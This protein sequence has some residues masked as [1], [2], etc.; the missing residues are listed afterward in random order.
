MKNLYESFIVTISMF[1]KL[2][3]PKVEWSAQNM[4][5][6]FT[7]L[8]IIG[9][10]VGISELLWQIIATKFALN[11]VFYSVVAVILPIIIT[12]GIHLDGYIDSCDAIFSYGDKDKKLAILSD[13]TVGAFGVLYLLIYLLL[14][15]GLWAQLFQQNVS[16]ISFVAPYIIGRVVGGFLIKLEQPAKKDGLM[17]IFKNSEKP[18][19][20]VFFLI[21][22]SIFV[23]LLLAYLSLYLLF[24]VSI[25]LLIFI[26]LCRRYVYKAFGG[27]TGDLVGFS[28]SMCELIS[29]CGLVVGGMLGW[30]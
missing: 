13:P 20:T 30:L 18:D 24:F 15:L 8:P 11:T 17:N 7:F 28:I 25:S 10:F 1:S 6:I 21:I 27:F 29:L 16:L 5:H 14:S 26:A 9:I 3:T 22:W 4:K 2:P 19:K 23:A 12:G